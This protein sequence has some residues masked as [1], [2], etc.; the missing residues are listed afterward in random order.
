MAFA[1]GT[2]I[3]FWFL[4]HFV[5]HELRRRS[6]AWLTGEA[7]VMA[8]VVERT[9]ANRLHDLIVEEIAD[10]TS[11]QLPND[12]G[13]AGPHGVSMFFS[14]FAPD[15]QIKLLAGTE[16][17]EA[18]LT[19]LENSRIRMKD[20]IPVDVRVVGYHYPFRV[21]A[22]SLRNGDRIFIGLSEE[23]Q[24][25]LLARL[26][27]EFELLGVVIA[28]LGGTI[29][30][31]T[32]RG[33][34]Q[35]VLVMS[36]MASRIGSDDLAQR[37]PV[38]E[39]N[40]EISHLASTLNGMLDRV[41]SSIQELHTITDSL[42]HDLRT[43]ITTVRGKLEHA[44]SQESEEKRDES[45]AIALEA[46][47]RMSDMLT[48][49]LDVAEANAD[50]LR[51]RL[52]PMDLDATVRSMVELYEPMLTEDGLSIEVESPGPMVVQA[53]PSLVHRLVANLFDN[54]VK[55]L[56]AGG[57]IVIRLERAGR[58]VRMVLEDNGPGFPAE[59]RAR[60]FQ[61][62]SKGKASE[63][64]G[65]GLAFVAAVIRSHKGKIVGENRK[66]GGIR[67]VMDL[68]AQSGEEVE[69]LVG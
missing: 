20:D 8:E 29:V 55:H 54:E 19:A 22:R 36:D 13:V 31:A 52:E 43:P 41:Q 11:K 12:S 27:W 33:M 61:R 66:G 15:G 59:V 53:D 23:G 69:E 64:Y 57:R 47:D 3:V 45:V 49:T 40:D 21:V 60:M 62:H 38:S 7:Q 9:P 2:A 6:D 10:L 50:S 32:T 48:R 1:V 14:Q 18:Q 67:L 42:A 17:S 16:T 56:P 65:L 35:R 51:L 37:L 44:L 4:Q 34:L 39:R 24:R 58:M 68:P 28:A 30:F 63:G 25:G 5:S 26:R 46:L